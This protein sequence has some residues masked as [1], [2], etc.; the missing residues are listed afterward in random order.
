[1]KNER[2]RVLVLHVGG[3]IGMVHGHEGF[4]PSAGFLEAYLDSM[5]ELA[6]ADMPEHTL[7]VLDPLL[8]SADMT[9]DDW[10]RIARVITSRYAEFDGFVVVHGTDTLAYTASALSFLLP[11][12]GK[13]VVLTGSQLS[14]TDPRSDGREHLV[15]SILLAGTTR[16]AEV[17]IYFAQRL[18]R[19]NRAQKVHNDRFAAFDSGN[20]PALAHAG[21]VIDVRQALVMEPGRGLAQVEL[22][23]RPEVAA[24]RIFPGIQARIIDKVVEA[25][26]EGL[27]LETYGAGNAPARDTGLLDA[28]ERATQRGVVI[29]NCSQC[30]GGRVRQGLYQTSSA[31]ARVGVVSGHDMTPEAAL[32]KLYCL[33]ASGLDAATVRMQMEQD[34]AGELTVPRR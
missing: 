22:P 10:V 21:T 23:R 31:L 29:V 32:T 24:L 15:T 33:L 7:A 3:T 17:C 12:L 20:F 8:D 26:L 18:L 19:G 30:H 2:A 11:G 34:L 14:L 16:I 1:M 4:G 13:P 6:R 9:P 25:P 27:V 28:L 5:P